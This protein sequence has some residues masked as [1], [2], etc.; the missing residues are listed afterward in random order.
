MRHFYLTSLMSRLALPSLSFSTI[1]PDTRRVSRSKEA[2]MD[3]WTITI[4]LRVSLQSLAPHGVRAVRKR[5]LPRPCKARM[6]TIIPIT[7]SSSMAQRELM[8]IK[9]TTQVPTRSHCQH[10]AFLTGNR[11]TVILRNLHQHGI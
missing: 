7:V 5:D 4:L 1:S 6:A 2:G 10:P 8:H 9:T 11:R 3:V